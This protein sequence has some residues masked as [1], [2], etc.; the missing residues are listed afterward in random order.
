MNDAANRHPRFL[1]RCLW[2]TGLS[3]SGKTTLAEGLARSLKADGVPYVLV[4]GDELRKGLC[5]DLGY[6]TQDRTENIRR[7]AEVCRILNSAGIVAIAA[8]ISP[9]AADRAMARQIVGEAA[10]REVWVATPL[11]ICERRDPKGLYR[12]ARAGLIKDFTGVAGDPY[13]PPLHADLVLNTE[14]YS[15]AGSVEKLRRLFEKA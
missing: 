2:L 9:R 5:A 1:P 14:H 4:D 15:V 13:E 6:S 10:F 11:E 8:L 7:A 12:K 3:A